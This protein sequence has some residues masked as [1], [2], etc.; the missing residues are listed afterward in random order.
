[1]GE[2]ILVV[3]MIRVSVCKQGRWDS[4]CV[5]DAGCCVVVKLAP[6]ES[7]KRKRKTS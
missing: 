2:M 4:F 7:V 6:L 5:S 1:M 3:A